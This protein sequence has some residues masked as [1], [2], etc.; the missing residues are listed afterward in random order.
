VA[1]QV[2]GRPADRLRTL[3]VLSTPHPAAFGA[4]LAGDGGSDQA[5]RSGYMDFFRSE[6]SEDVMLAYD[7]GLLQLVLLGSGLTEQEA[8]PSLE[9][10][11]TSDALGAALNWYRAAD[12]TLVDGLGPVVAPTL[13]IWSTNDVALGREAAEA[14]A[15]FVDGPYA[16]R[17]SRGSTTGSATTRPIR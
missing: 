7:A 16:S 2:A 4:A 17:C 11:S 13:Y 8:A 15:R 14:T 3:T 9:A 12:I 5:E 10:L 6:G 1:W